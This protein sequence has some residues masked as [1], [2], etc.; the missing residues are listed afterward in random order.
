[1]PEKKYAHDSWGFKLGNRIVKAM[2]RLGFSPAPHI[3]ILS[4]RG[5]KSGKMLSTPMSIV[6]IEGT[7]YAIALDNVNWVLNARAAGWGFLG[8]G[9]HQ[10][11]VTMT[12]V[13]LDERRRVLRQYPVQIPRGAE[14]FKRAH[15]ISGDSESFAAMAETLPVFRFEPSPLS[16]ISS[17]ATNG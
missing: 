12:E 13:P 2:S 14:Q 4:I 9:S 1:M 3:Y 8:R 16:D 17:T 11:R 6:S 15:G 7:R 5:R 10:E